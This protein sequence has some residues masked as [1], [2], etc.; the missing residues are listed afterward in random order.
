MTEE[1][2]Q[3]ARKVMQSANYMRGLITKAK[4]NVAKW[5]KIEDVH[6][7][8]LREANAAG[9]KKC[10]DKA[11]KFLEDIRVRFAALNFPDPNIVAEVHRCKECGC[12]IAKGNELCG[13]CACED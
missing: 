5:T 12:K 1:S 6:R 3:Q 13:E 10:L 11:M 8:E 7:Q 2:F 4:G 9:A